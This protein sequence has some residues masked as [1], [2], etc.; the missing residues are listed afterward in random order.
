MEWI[1]L[2]TVIL[3]LLRPI[4]QAWLE[5]LLKRAAADLE[6][7]GVS[8][9][10]CSSL[11]AEG[12]LWAAAS[13]ILEADSERRTWLDWIGLGRWRAAQRRRYFDATRKVALARAGQC[14]EAAFY[15]SLGV[16]PLTSDEIRSVEREG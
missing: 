15:P 5:N 9:A 16:E 7:Q 14:Y 13:R 2:V 3:Q 11:E 1:A 10:G 6:A 12:R 8:L 4:L